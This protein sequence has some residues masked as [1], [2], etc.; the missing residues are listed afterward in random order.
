MKMS[1]P[2]ASILFLGQ[3]DEWSLCDC[4]L[5]MVCYF[6]VVGV[7]VVGAGGLGGDRGLKG[8]DEKCEA[9]DN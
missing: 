9:L 3:E 1:S 8:M 7:L 6:L 2:P 5:Q 4:L